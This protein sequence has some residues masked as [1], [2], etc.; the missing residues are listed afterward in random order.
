MELT[1]NLYY[2]KENM[3]PSLTKSLGGHGN[4]NQKFGERERV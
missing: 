2:Y 1:K 4:E 3:A